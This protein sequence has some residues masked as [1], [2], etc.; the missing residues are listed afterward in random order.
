MLTSAFMIVI[1]RIEKHHL[2]NYFRFRKSELKLFF[3]RQIANKIVLSIKKIRQIAQ[4]LSI[5]HQELGNS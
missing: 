3:F 1:K 4:K 2:D 5:M